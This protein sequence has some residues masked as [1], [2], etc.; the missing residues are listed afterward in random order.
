MEVQV[1][2]VKTNF[3]NPRRTAAGIS[4]SKFHLLLAVVSK[5]TPFKCENVDAYCNVVGGF[6]IQDPAADLAICAAILSSRAEKEIAANT[7]IFGEVGLSGEV[8]RVPNME[9][10][11]S[12]AAKM[13][14][15]KIICPR[16]PKGQKIP[17]GI[18]V[19]E[20]R[21]VGELAKVVLGK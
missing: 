12:E 13:G 4:I 3:G 2:T 9:T 7:I 19:V 20:I 17:K 16:V 1:L 14:F 21:S 6:R 10:R 11:L 5:F 15:E 8:R 18:N